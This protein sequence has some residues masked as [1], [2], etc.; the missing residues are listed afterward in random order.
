MY[1]AIR[2]RG[3][4]KM[5][6]DAKKTMQLL[7]MD[8]VNHLVLVKQSQI[9]MLQKVRSF[10]TF[11]E[12]GEE[13]LALLLEKRA[14]L[15]GNKKPGE[16]FLKENKLGS[17]KELA[18]QIIE[19]KLILEK[20]SIKPVFRLGPPKKG[21]ERAGIKKPYSIGGALGYRASDIN[22]LVLRMI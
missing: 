20:L 21:Y 16:K 13:T 12:I 11:G 14:R 18:K 2:V 4:V 15:A 19:G 5:A 7:G 6:P 3:S 1:A 17:W 9:P 22:K 8:R 10:T